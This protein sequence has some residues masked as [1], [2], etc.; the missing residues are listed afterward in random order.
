MYI[1][2][3]K[4]I[5]YKD[6]LFI[7]RTLP[8]EGYINVSVGDKVEPFN[9][10]GTCKVTYEVFDLGDKFKPQGGAQRLASY[11]SG[12][13]VGS[14]GRKKFYAPY[15]GTLEKTENGL[16]SKP[17]IWAIQADLKQ[18]RF[19]YFQGVNFRLYCPARALV[20]IFFFES[21]LLNEAEQG[22]QTVC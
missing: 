14:A 22:L 7:E 20:F 4:K 11:A 8:E 19:Q 3:V 1:P 10:L 2:V 15:N 16:K 5:I 21:I 17:K 13:L 12:M 9:K 18:L 6:N